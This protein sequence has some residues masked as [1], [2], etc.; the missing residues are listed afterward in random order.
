[1]KNPRHSLLRGLTVQVLAIT[2][3]PLTLLLL[4]IAF[5]SVFRHQQD[6]RSLVGERDERAVQA[7]AAA[8][9][10]ELHHRASNISSLVEIAELMNKA[11]TIRATADLTEDFDGGIAYLTPDKQLI[12]TTGDPQFWNAALK[13]NVTLADSR[14][15]TSGSQ[16]KAIFSNA[17]LDPQSKRAMVIVSQYSAPM[18]II[19]AGAFSPETL[20]NKVISTSYTTSERATVYL[21]DSSRQPLYTSHADTAEALPADHPGVAEALRG[22]SGTLYVQM[23]ESE[24]VIAYSPI[25]PTGWV[26]ITEESW[27]EVVSPSLQMTQMAPLVIVPAFILTLI[28]LWFVAT[29]IVQPLQKLEDQAAALAWGDFEAIEK[30]VGGITEIRQLQMELAEMARKVQSAQEGLHDYIGAITAAQEEERMRLAREIHDDTIQA[31]VALKQRVQLAGKSVRTGSARDQLR[32]LEDLAEKTVENLRRLTRA[33]RPIY[34]E[35]LG[36]V[37][38]LSMLANESSQAGELNVDFRRV[39]EER[40]LSS[41]VELALYRIAQEALNNVKNHA[42]ASQATLSITFDKEI[43]LEV[44]DNGV[45]FTVP[46]SP[47][48]FAPGGH[49]GLL[50][51]RERAELIGG[52]LEVESSAG[53]GTRL[54]VRLNSSPNP[55]RKKKRNS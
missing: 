12:T 31:V 53:R 8:L 47:T 43:K 32:E 40:R 16:T 50:G 46:K 33:L 28:A 18:Q 11:A 17:F 14:G 54:S 27:Q 6:M 26:L 44:T 21:L 2:V 51:M 52:R 34:L 41:E 24:H 1:M 45:G 3:L 9:D 7:A 19:V 35:D 55:F 39:G 20:A 48:E 4:F 38:A 49:F 23:G 29:K 30:N 36:L 13:A 25:T 10:A 5:S 42:N 37:T 15:I 22:E